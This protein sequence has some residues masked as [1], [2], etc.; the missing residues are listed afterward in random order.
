[1]ILGYMWE[2][3]KRKIE[4]FEGPALEIY[5]DT[6]TAFQR[7]HQL[8][9]SGN[10]TK[11]HLSWTLKLKLLNVTNGKMGRVTGPQLGRR[12]LAHRVA[13]SVLL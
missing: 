7:Y 3:Y 11:A 9:N 5:R 12:V 4:N 8:T 1:M 10:A 2:S 13:L 6:Y